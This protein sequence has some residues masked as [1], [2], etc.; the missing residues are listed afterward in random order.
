MEVNGKEY[1]MWGQFVNRKEEWVGGVLQD[2]Y[3]ETSETEIIDITL[4][5]I[6]DTDAFF[7]VQGK[8]FKCGGS[9]DC[10]GVIGVTGGDKGWITLMG[11]AGHTW[12]FKQKKEGE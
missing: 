6:G 12:R 3:G 5:P 4:K 10:L 11:Y 7:S 8:D 1:L 2:L 9:T